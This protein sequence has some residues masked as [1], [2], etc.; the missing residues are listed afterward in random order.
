MPLLANFAAVLSILIP[1]YGDDCSQLVVDLQR[2]ARQLSHAYEIIV[3]DDK[4][5]S[6]SFRQN[7]E[8]LSEV[9]NVR[10]IAN[11][12]NLGRAANRNSLAEKAQFD[13]LLFIDADAQVTDPNFLSRYMH[14]A[15]EADVVVGGTSYPAI[16]PDDKALLLR[17]MYGVA[18]EARIAQQRAR[19][20]YQAFSSFNFLIY[21]ELFQ[22]I[23]FDERLREYGHE[24]T[25]FGFQL[26]QLSAKLHHIDNPLLHNGLV[27][28]E[29]FLLSTRAAIANL[30]P[31]K[32]WYPTFE[33]RL[34]RTAQRLS[35]LLPA[36]AQTEASLVRQLLS[37]SPS[38]LAFDAFKLIHYD[39]TRRAYEQSQPQ[40]P[41]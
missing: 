37:S 6:A 25:I 40:T 19:T 9:A 4:E 24:D 20:P 16:A 32:Q 13:C 36:L 10:L 21:K 18:R 3:Q 12:S 15:G 23:K 7:Q 30:H 5:D 26:E 2:Q 41:R 39:R 35:W 17:Y 29:Q 34:M 11:K 28:A 22:Q 38:L 14:A 33:T 8:A 27:T 1:A 31:L